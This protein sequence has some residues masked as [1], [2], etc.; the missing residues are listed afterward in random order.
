MADPTPPSSPECFLLYDGQC[1][2]CVKAKKGIER[3]ED[4][5]DQRNL[6][7]IPYQSEEA[8]HMLGLLYRPGRPDVAY[9]VQSDGTVAG[10]LDAFLLLLPGLKGGRFI[11][12]V[13]KLPLMRPIAYF[14]Y[15]VFARYRYDLF[16]QVPLE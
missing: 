11:S 12:L 16:G 14:L 8:K 13:L 10:G 7:M 15:R 9:L 2:F 4:R 6:R 1:R 3:L 5:K